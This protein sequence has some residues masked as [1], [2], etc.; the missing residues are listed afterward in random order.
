MDFEVLILGT[1]PNAYYMARCCFEAYHKKPYVIGRSP[2]AFTT[3]SDILNVSYESEMWS[4]EGFLKVL[5]NFQK[6]HKAPIV[7][8]STNET[9]TEFVSANKK[10]LEKRFIFNFPSPQVIKSLTN[11]ELFYKTYQDSKL[12]FPKTV[13]YDCKKDLGVPLEFDYPVVLKPANVVIYNHI[14]FVGKNKIYKLNSEQELKETIELIK[15]NGY[16]DKL[17]IQEF[18][19]RCDVAVFDAVLYVNSKG[20]CEFMSFAQIGLQERTNNMVGNAAVLINGFNTT[21]GDIENQVKVIKEFME[22]IQ[23]RGFAEVDMKYDSRDNTFKVLEINARQ[24]RSSYYVAAL[25]NNLVKVLVDDCIN[26]LEN[27]FQLLTDKVMLSFVPRGIIKKYVTNEEFRKEALRLWP[28]VVSPMNAPCD[29]N[30]KRFLMLRKR[31][32]NYYKEYKNSYWRS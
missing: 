6:E 1:D 26:N 19:T 21:N 16:D 13:Y 31:W 25:G 27:D 30:F 29:R 20:K 12:V 8:I 10:K 2:L 4:E 28:N 22:E 17:I 14:K 11:K 3:Y 9:Y 32:M 24:G 23:Y 15:N 7:L 18:I 5:D